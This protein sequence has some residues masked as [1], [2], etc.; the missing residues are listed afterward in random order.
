[1]YE[2]IKLTMNTF[3]L[4]KKYISSRTVEYLKQIPGKGYFSSSI[5]VKVTAVDLLIV[6][7][8]DVTYTKK[9]SFILKEYI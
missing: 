4:N 7:T 9:Y 6:N 5:T 3:L 8:I 2:L 1:M